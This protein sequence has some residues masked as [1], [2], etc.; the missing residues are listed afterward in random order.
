MATDALTRPWKTHALDAATPTPWR[1]GGG[2]TRELLCWPSHDA[3][4]LRFSVA[5][6]QRDGPF[7]PFPGVQRWFAV[8]DGAGVALRWADATHTLTPQS[9]PLAFDGAVAP[10]ARLLDGPTHDINLMLRDLSASLVVVDDSAVAS[11]FALFTA[12]P[13]ALTLPMHTASI[14]MHTLVQFNGGD[15]A[16]SRPDA[17]RFTGRGWWVLLDDG[18]SR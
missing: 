10:H 4:Q 8:L 13:G 14:A 15:G 16:E 11:P 17:A 3:W 7:S 2:Q 18:G 1:N 5:T 6:I 12:T 9:P